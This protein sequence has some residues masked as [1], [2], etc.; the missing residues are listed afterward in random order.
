VNASGV[1][2]CVVSVGNELLFGETVDTNAAWL[3]RALASHGITVMRRY[4]VADVAEEIQHAV[5]EAADIADLVLVSGGLGPTSDDITR[6]TVAELIGASL[7]IDRSLL[8]RLRE[9][10]E[11]R[12]YRELPAPNISQAEVPSG[13]RVL[14]NPMGTAPGLAMR[15]AE[16]WVVLLPGVPRELMGIF[17]GEFGE[18]LDLE[19]GDRALPVCHRTV[20]TTGVPESRLA[21]LIEHALARSP[22]I[23]ELATDV[24]VA[25]LPDLR[26]VDLRLT[27]RGLH[28]EA[29]QVQLD[30]VLHRLEPVVE[31][32]RFRAQNGDIV[33]SVTE[34]LRS[35]SMR[36]A[37]AESCTAGLMAKRITDLPGASDIYVGGVVAYDNAVK[38]ALL[39]VPEDLIATHGAVSEPVANQM[40]A[41]VAKRLGADV[42]LAVTGVAGPGGGTDEKP[43][44]TVWLAVS[45]S[46]STTSEHAR[47]VGDRQAVRERAAQAAFALLLRSLQG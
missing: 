41:G 24:S 44:G 37:T 28:A 11:A 1:Q 43:V 35:R 16:T 34:A 47:F 46:D 45:D 5:G 30:H 10:F 32:W 36:L 2:A 14:H 22:A 7:E 4:T 20:H 40:A 27:V 19:F 31:R 13:A 33:E 23:S 17:G 12:G 39:Q 18:F 29:A 15:L 26:G 38:E 6:Q 42:G 3:G 9:R 8:E 25:Y 21:E